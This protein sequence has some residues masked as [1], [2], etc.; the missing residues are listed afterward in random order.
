[1]EWVSKSRAQRSL[2]E[3]DRLLP[4]HAQGRLHSSPQPSS[5]R[6]AGIHLLGS[7]PDF[8]SMQ[9]RLDKVPGFPRHVSQAR[10]AH[11]RC[12]G[13]Q[14]GP[15]PSRSLP[16]PG[17]GGT[18]VCALLSI[19]PHLPPGHPQSCPT[20]LH[21]QL[22]V[23]AQ[24]LPAKPART[25]DREPGGQ[26]DRLAELP[27]DAARSHGRETVLEPWASP[28][29]EVQRIRDSSRRPGVNRRPPR[30]NSKTTP[31]EE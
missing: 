8:C 11:R 9:K 12:H 26:E 10:C 2:G 17:C 3:Q 24:T 28:P 27:A 31:G 23:S 15:S 25:G 4:C 30:S 1:M 20:S 7:D 29:Q 22:A 19:Q 5:A 6:P 21:S 18:A 14:C 16:S 13:G